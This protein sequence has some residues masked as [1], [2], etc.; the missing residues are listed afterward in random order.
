MYFNDGFQTF[1]FHFTANIKW[2]SNRK[3]KT[4]KFFFFPTNWNSKDFTT[5]K[6]TVYLK[7]LQTAFVLAKHYKE[8]SV[9]KSSEFSFIQICRKVIHT[10]INFLYHNRRRYLELYSTDPTKREFYLQLHKVT[11]RTQN[12]EELASLQLMHRTF[13]RLI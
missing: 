7:C 9:W 3:I 10:Q 11:I 13:V 2:I 12:S 8:T 4:K 1:L 5:L 6:P